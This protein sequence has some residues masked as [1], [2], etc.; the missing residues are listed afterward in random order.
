MRLPK[1]FGKGDG[2]GGGLKCA[3][4]GTDL[5]RGKANGD[6]GLPQA[7]GLGKRETA[8]PNKG[9]GSTKLRRLRKN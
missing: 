3:R 6:F 9:E 2:E 1:I 8:R 5:N 7:S 4:G